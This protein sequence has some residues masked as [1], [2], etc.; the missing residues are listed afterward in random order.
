MR[1]KGIEIDRRVLR[2]A[3]GTRGQLAIADTTDQ[4][5]NRPTKVASLSQSELVRAELRDVQIVWLAQDRM[6]LTG[7]EQIND[8][9]GQVVEFRQSWLVMLDNGPSIPEM[10]RRKVNPNT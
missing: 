3:A 4:G 10:S 1:N 7:Y 5:K 8:D 6:T 9:A 2:D